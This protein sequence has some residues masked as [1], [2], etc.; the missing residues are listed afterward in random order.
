MIHTSGESSEVPRAESPSFRLHNRE[1]LALL[2]TTRQRPNTLQHNGSLVLPPISNR[3][4]LNVLIC[5]G[6][7]KQPK[8]AIPSTQITRHQSFRFPLSMCHQAQ[9]IYYQ[10]SFIPLFHTTQHLSPPSPMSIPH[11]GSSKGATQIFDSTLLNH[12]D[13]L[14]SIDKPSPANSSTTFLGYDL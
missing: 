7:F 4:E 1:I 14:L 5:S 13:P 6:T 3:L 2:S 12:G 8:R 10:H 9:Y 11:H